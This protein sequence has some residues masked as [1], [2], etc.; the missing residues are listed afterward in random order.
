MKKILL[1]IP[2]LYFGN[3]QAQESLYTSGG[4]GSGSGGTVG[5]SVGQLAFNESSDGTYTVSPG[6]QQP[7]EISNILSLEKYQNLNFKLLAFP[8]PTTNYLTLSF[9]K[10]NN[11]RLTYQL[12]DL[13]GRLIQ[14]K[15]K[16][17][18][19]E[20]IS[21]KHLSNATYYI[22]VLEKNQIIKTF[23]IIKN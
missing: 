23:K 2:L 3:I 19:N 14:T 16:L 10:S 11:E 21:M 22:N 20:T 8:N 12:F 15:D 9:E 13:N 18:T 4:N 1:F 5:Y 17:K 6:V 7:F